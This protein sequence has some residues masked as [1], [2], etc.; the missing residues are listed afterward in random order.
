MQPPTKPHTPTA[1]LPARHGDEDELYRR[2]HRELHRAVAHVVRAPRELIED[3]CQTAWSILLRRQPDRHTIFGWLRTVAIH[4]AYRL[5]AIERRDARLERLRSEDGDWHDIT[6]DPRSLEDAVEALEALR[7]V[8]SLPERQRRD[9][10]LKVVGYSYEEIR[11][12]TPGRTM[13]N[14]NKSLVKARARIRRSRTP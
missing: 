4:E 2:H 10:V 7:V 14:V 9:F 12:L 3:A 11:L 1:A 8:A 5:S 13:T 6:A